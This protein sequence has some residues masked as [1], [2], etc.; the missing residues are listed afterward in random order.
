MKNDRKMS[1]LKT[2]ATSALCA[3]AAS[4][5]SNAAA[6]AGTCF[7]GVTIEPSF[8]A[9]TTT[10][11]SNLGAWYK[12]T[13]GLE[14]VKEFAFPDGSITGALMRRG[15]FVVEFFHRDDALVG[16]KIET[17]AKPEQWAG[18]M[19]FGIFTDADLPK[20][21]SCLTAQGVE[22]TRIFKDDNL[23]IDLLMV[24][25]PEN[26]MIEVIQRHADQ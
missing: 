23:G 6:E 3:I 8:V 24:K 26:N 21:K 5:S 10:K 16:A 4:N 18:V 9:F 12:Q 15:E 11:N 7:A 1:R 25:D 14:T 17:E 2:L 13:F 19:K 20:L 22:A